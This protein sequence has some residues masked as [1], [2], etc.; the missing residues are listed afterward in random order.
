M[1]SRTASDVLIA[2][3]GLS[4]LAL[5][6]RLVDAG[7]SGRIILV[8]RTVGTFRDRTWCFWGEVP[9]ALAPYVARSWRR[10]RLATPET[11]V[12]GRLDREPYHLIRGETWG[13]AVVRKLSEDP[14][15]R[16]VR[17]EVRGLTDHGDHVVLE[18][19]Q[20][21]LRGDWGFRGLGH[22]AAPPQDLIQHF[23]GWEVET[24]RPA[25]DPRVATL[26]EFGPSADGAAFHYV[27]PTSR[28]RAL[29]EYTVF[30]SSPLHRGA[31]D[32]R[33]AAYLERTVSGPWRRLRAEYGALPLMRRPPP[34]QESPR[35]LR[36]GAS[37][38]MTKPSTGYTFLSTLAQ[39]E[40]LARTLTRTG[41][42]EPLP[43]GPARFRFYDRVLLRLLRERPER[44]S[45]AF[46]RLFEDNDFDR[47]LRFLAERTAPH[48][49]LWLLSALPVLPFLGL[50][51]PRRWTEVSAP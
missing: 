33:V 50:L 24:E 41:R 40:H 34:Q 20:G 26:M 15:V 22:P 32:Q 16:F 6:E 46:L 5:A 18:T 8:D 44:A 38:G 9:A 42:P 30:S 17:G 10:L 48:E 25:F 3:A 19:S 39:A 11:S 35:I 14:R 2:G 23:G 13:N 4:G 49:E 47:V 27:L 28:T 51:E 29:V 37:G 36:I 7:H 31:Y 21:S 45:E 1:S 12:V 43:A